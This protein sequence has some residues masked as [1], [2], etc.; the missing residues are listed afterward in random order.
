MSPS[1]PTDWIH[2][3]GMVFYGYH[4][5]D[6]AEK[7]LGQRFL[8]DLSVAFDLRRAGH[9]DDLADTVN[10]AHLYRLAREVGEGPSCNLLEAV[11]QRIADR[12]LAETTVPAVRVRVRKPGVAIKG[13]ILAA[14]TVEITRRR[15]RG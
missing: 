10:Y 9:S 5:V 15:G 13:S 14:A 6:P 12:V 1:E 2:L 8:V 3:E 4:G 7:Q 11:A